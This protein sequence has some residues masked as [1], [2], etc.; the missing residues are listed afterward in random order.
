[1]S[2]FLSRSPA[3][4]PQPVG[5][6]V[7]YK[8]G[9]ANQF[10]AAII[11]SSE[12]AII[13]ESL[14]GT[15]TSWNRGAEK[16]FGYRRQDAMGQS[17]SI[18]HTEG[19]AEELSAILELIQQGRSATHFETKRKRKDGTHIDVSISVSPVRD[20]SHRVIG[21]AKII[22]DITDRKRT[23]ELNGRA[24]KLAVTGRLAAS[25][26]HEINNPLAAL[27]NLLYLLKAEKLS[28]QGSE[29]LSMADREL[30][31][32]AHITTQALGF[33]KESG[34]ASLHQLHQ[35][36]DQALAIHQH[37]IEAGSIEVEE[38]CEKSISV[39]CH[40]GEIKQV[41]VNLIGNAL[42]AMNGNG[43]LRIRARTVSDSKETYSAIHLSIGDNGPGIPKEMLKHLF[44]PFNT[45]KGQTRTGLGL[46]MCEQI[47][48]RHRGRIKI[49]SSQHPTWHGTVVHVVLPAPRTSN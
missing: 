25:V 20:E 38:Q 15:I 37:R 2:S 33:Y 47:V 1:V 23:E 30:G 31:R 41:F 48:V 24:E 8:D 27:T 36:L 16:M 39:L 42:D 46:W 10:L 49:K 19:N 44:E 14:D 4:E 18:L 6:A 5:V 9:E 29:F 40:G 7:I 26:A 12:D 35:L 34:P 13:G 21:A 28:E 11:E 32:I 22:R 17:V 3:S 43:R 45:T